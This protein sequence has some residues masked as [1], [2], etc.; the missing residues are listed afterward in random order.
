MIVRW[1]VLEGLA[2]IILGLIIALLVSESR[3][4]SHLLSDKLTVEQALKCEFSARRLA[5]I[6]FNPQN[7]ASLTLKIESQ[8]SNRS[9]V[10][11]EY[12]PS[13]L[14]IDLVSNKTLILLVP[15]KE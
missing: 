13:L 9:Y 15:C 8:G 14:I 11:S 3:V 1:Y 5:E 6:T 10:C 12:S 7:F 4:L 2:A